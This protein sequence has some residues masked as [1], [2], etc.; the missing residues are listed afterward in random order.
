MATKSTCVE[1]AST[2]SDKAMVFSIKIYEIVLPNKLQQKKASLSVILKQC[3]L[4]TQVIFF[5]ILQ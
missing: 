4:L 3:Y 2:D 1:D 5:S